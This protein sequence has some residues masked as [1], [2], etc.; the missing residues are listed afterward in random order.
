MSVQKRDILSPSAIEQPYDNSVYAGAD[1]HCTEP[2]STGA[3][4]DS[5]AHGDV[6]GWGAA[7]ARAGK[8]QNTDGAAGFA[9]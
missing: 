5:T 4:G 1:L 6:A 2:S 9:L 3:N 8:V 7:S